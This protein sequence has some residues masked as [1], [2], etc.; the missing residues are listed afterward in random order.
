MLPD[1]KRDYLEALQKIHNLMKDNEWVGGWSNRDNV[2][3]SI[4]EITGEF[5]E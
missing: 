1:L 3:R 5:F 2:L 4:N